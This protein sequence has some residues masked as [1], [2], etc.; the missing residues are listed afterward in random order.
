MFFNQ[1]RQTRNHH[2]HH[3][4][5]HRVSCRSYVAPRDCIASTESDER[6]KEMK[7]L[8]VLRVLFE[9]TNDEIRCSVM[10]L[11]LLWMSLLLTRVKTFVW[12]TFW[13]FSNLFRLKSTKACMFTCLYVNYCICVC[14]SNSTV[15]TACQSQCW[16]AMSSRLALMYRQPQNHNSK[17]HRAQP[18]PTLMTTISTTVR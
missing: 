4:Q 17:Q 6:N 2:H 18:T 7:I 12:Y 14:G 10:Q 1:K 5:H 13:S 3:H 9:R 15:L 8:T 16:C 11:D